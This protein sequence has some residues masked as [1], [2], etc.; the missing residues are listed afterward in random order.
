MCLL[1]QGHVGLALNVL[2][3]GA[4]A[5]GWPPLAL[6]PNSRS[7]AGNR[8][9]GGCLYQSIRLGQVQ[10]QTREARNNTFMFIKTHSWLKMTY[11]LFS[12]PPFFDVFDMICCVYHGKH[13]A[14]ADHLKLKSLFIRDRRNRGDRGLLRCRST[15]FPSCLAPLKYLIHSKKL[16]SLLFCSSISF[17]FDC[18]HETILSSH[19]HTY[20][21][22]QTMVFFSKYK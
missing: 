3:L 14:L 15:E 9:G 11:T 21:L 6:L 13:K 19:S 12:G 7:R 8:V 18:L 10:D 17:L 1:G 4:R 2:L 20:A 5:H 16:F 22:Q